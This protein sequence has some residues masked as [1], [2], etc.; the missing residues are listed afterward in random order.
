MKFIFK[1]KKIFIFLII[2]LIWATLYNGFF[3]FY[4]IN[5]MGM[6]ISIIVSLNK[7]IILV[8][9]FI[10]YNQVNVSC[11]SIKYLDLLQALDF[12]SSD[13]SYCY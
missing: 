3:L 10:K 9:K 5:F 2:F 1:I 12:S 4:S 6:F 8:N 11:C 13:F 7:K